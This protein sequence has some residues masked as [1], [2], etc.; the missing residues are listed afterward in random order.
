M[1]VLIKE[2]SGKSIAL[3]LLA[4]FAF[5]AAS[6]FTG[7]YSQAKTPT[8]NNA[9][10]ASSTI[11]LC[12][13]LI[14]TDNAFY[15]GEDCVTGAVVYGGPNNS[16]NVSG[17]N[18][19]AIVNAMISS[20]F[21]NPITIDILS[22][23]FSVTSQIIDHEQLSLIGAGEALTR[24]YEPVGLGKP[25]ILLDAVNGGYSLGGTEPDRSVISNMAID[26]GWG[27]GG[28]GQTRS[29]TCLTVQSPT[30]EVTISNLDIYHCGGFG[31]NTSIGAFGG[32]DNGIGNTETTYSNLEVDHNQLS[33]MVITHS[34]D[35][36][37]T[38]LYSGHNGQF[39]FYMS[40]GGGNSWTHLVG[41]S[42]NNSGFYI[43]DENDRFYTTGAYE[44]LLAGIYIIGNYSSDPLYNANPLDDVFYGSLVYGTGDTGICLKNQCANNTIGI[45]VENASDVSFIGGSSQALY[46][47]AGHPLAEYGMHFAGDSNIYVSDVTVV[48]NWDYPRIL[49][50]GVNSN[51]SIFDCDG[52]NYGPGAV[53]SVY[54]AII[55][56][57][58]YTFPYLTYP[59]LYVLESGNLTNLSLEIVQASGLVSIAPSSLGNPILVEPWQTLRILYSG[60]S[61][62][63]AIIPSGI[64]AGATV[65]VSPDHSSYAASPGTRI[66]I[67]GTVLPAPGVSGTNATVSITNPNGIQLTL[68]SDP[69]NA[70]TGAFN[71]LVITGS[72]ATWING[73]YV[74]MATWSASANSQAYSGSL[75]FEYGTTSPATYSSTT[76]TETVTKTSQINTTLTKSVTTTNTAQTTLTNTT[77][78]TSTATST[79]TSTAQTTLTALFSTT[80][81]VQSLTTQTS[82][83]F[84]TS[85]SLL[86][87]TTVNTAFTTLTST[88]TMTSTNYAFL[89]LGIVGVTVATAAGAF[90]AQARRRKR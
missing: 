89:A 67:S 11:Q 10:N 28:K 44:N 43:Q 15:Y 66:A 63:V 12:S 76:L 27:D 85:T 39:G 20:Y 17:T 35:S 90:A 69:V 84:A 57:S 52:Y 47:A 71:N 5:S 45:N 86:Q 23:N 50:N 54:P 68:N 21:P 13:F 75:T 58:P 72:G 30:W 3:I 53:A 80:Q 87:S 55:G 26:G 36:T 62:L 49:V 46:P 4:L 77:T 82:Q 22:G 24:L 64:A 70:K 60:A 88:S 6:G 34:A 9:P 1:A 78:A 25:M 79:V 18:F 16:G 33:G 29:D 2:L 19:A 8:I 56:P 48:N 32:L 59:A 81:T 41:D 37:G 51:I 14:F 65:L 73:T 42:N 38:D 31:I 7:Y 61:P 40:A 74:I 83:V